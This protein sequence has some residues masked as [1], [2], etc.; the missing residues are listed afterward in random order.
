MSRHRNVRGYNYDEGSGEQE[1]A[2]ELQGP[3][4]TPPQPPVP[5][6]PPPPPPCPF[7]Q[8][9]TPSPGGPFRPAAVSAGG[10][11]GRRG[12]A[13]GVVG[14]EKQPPPFPSP[15]LPSAGVGPG[16]V[17]GLAPL[18]PPPP[19]FPARAA[20]RAHVA[21]PPPSFRALSCCRG[22]PGASTR[23]KRGPGTQTEPWQGL[24]ALP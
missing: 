9:R 11:R 4:R 2:A 18:P 1:P 16:S 22:L 12:G 17:R 10:W 20:G 7:P 14:G 3:P 5:S 8:A 21:A 15:A 19:P 24:P 23:G 13:V 6:R